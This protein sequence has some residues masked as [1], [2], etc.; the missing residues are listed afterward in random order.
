MNQQKSKKFRQTF[1]KNFREQLEKTTK[2]LVNKKIQEKI[3]TLQNN[4]NYVA[5][6]HDIMFVISCVLLISNIVFIILWLV[7]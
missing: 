2:E 3:N 6:R 4:L 1:N 7:K 5:K